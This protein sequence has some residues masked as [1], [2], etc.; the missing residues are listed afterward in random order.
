MAVF[1]PG[2]SE[3][4]C[5]CNRVR[6]NFRVSFRKDNLG[7]GVERGNTDLRSKCLC[8]LE[9]TVAHFVCSFA[10]AQGVHSTNEEC[11]VLLVLTKFKPVLQRFISPPI[12]LSVLILTWLPVTNFVTDMSN[13]TVLASLHTCCGSPIFLVIGESCGQQIQPLGFLFFFWSM[14][15]TPVSCP[16]MVGL[17][18]GTLGI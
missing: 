8:V 17:C 15:S 3:L 2:W 18:Q 12:P 6:K 11:Y 7:G 5:G 14:H 9:S 4:G 10:W 16:V 1:L 13:S